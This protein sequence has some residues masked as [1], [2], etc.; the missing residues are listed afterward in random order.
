MK[1]IRNKF[2]ESRLFQQ[3]T[4]RYEHLAKRDQRF[5]LGL[6][7]FS[8]FFGFYLLLWSPVSLWSQQQIKDYDQQVETL[9]WLQQHIDVLAEA[10]NSKKIGA[11]QR[12]MP[13][14]I[15]RVARQ[16]DLT[17]SRI[18]P[19]KKGLVVNFDDAAYQKIVGWLVALQTNYLIS[20][21]KAKWVRLKEEGRIKGDFYLEGS[22]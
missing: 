4:F 22:G 6:L 18:Q 16:N 10:E 20:V 14:I 15:S 13:A 9:A 3:L 8:V 19:D 17:V 12:E 1:K 11:S 5:L 7:V 21:Q 2:I